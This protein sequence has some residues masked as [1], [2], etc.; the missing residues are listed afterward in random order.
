MGKKEKDI[1]QSSFPLPTLGK[2]LSTIRTD[3]YNGWGFAT[4]RGLDVNALSPDDLTTVY[5]GLTS[6]IAE[7]RGKQNQEGTMMSML[8][9]LAIS[10]KLTG[11]Y[12]EYSEPQR[13]GRP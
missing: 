8:P 12:S 6:Y 11:G 13:G 1:D 7:K 5:L 2:T 4:L 10:L 9:G 3:L